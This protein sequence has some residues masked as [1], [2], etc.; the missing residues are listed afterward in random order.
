MVC[1]FVCGFL[2]FCGVLLVWGLS[3]ECV[4]WMAVARMKNQIC[5]KVAAQAGDLYSEAGRL[6]RDQNVSKKLE[7]VGGCCRDHSW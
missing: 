4:V 1:C 7:K 5:A 3:I 2:L 6:V